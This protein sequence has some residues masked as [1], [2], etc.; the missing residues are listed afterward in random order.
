MTHASGTPFS[1]RRPDGLIIRG[2]HF[3][4][5]APGRRPAVILSHGFNGCFADLLNRGEEFSAAGIHCFLFDFCGGGLR[6]T[7]DG[8]LSDMMTLETEITDLQTV[9]A[10][11]QAQESVDPSNLFLMGESQGGMVSILTAAR[12][13]SACRGL[14]LWFPALVIPEDSQRRLAQGDHRVF[15]IPLCPDYDRIA[16]KADPWSFMPTFENPVLLVHGDRDPIISVPYLEKAQRLFPN[17][18]LRVLPGAGHGFGGKD[19]R[20]AMDTTLAMI[21][22]AAAI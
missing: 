5:N 8:K 10:H 4:A 7:S 15:G 9:I 11:A 20:F 21:R 12:L 13:P 6:T 17:A 16:A 1:L 14:I 19:Y 18:T 2:V 22:E 3:A